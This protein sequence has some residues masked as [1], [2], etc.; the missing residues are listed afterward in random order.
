M[1][2]ITNNNFSDILKQLI[3]LLPSSYNKETSD[4]NYYRLLRALALELENAQVEVKQLS[5]D[6]YLKT[7]SPER[8]FNNF[9]TLVKLKKNADWDD[10]KYR[11]LI[12]GVMQSLLR[13]PTKQSL[14]DG[15]K[16]FT[17]FNVNVYELYKDMDRVD[18]SLYE[19]LSPQFSF[20]LEIEKP[21]EDYA[22]QANLI[23]DANYIV[24]IIKPAHTINLI[25]TT[26]VSDE[27]YR[28]SYRERFGID[29]LEDQ[30]PPDQQ[31]I[32]LPDYYNMDIVDIE[33]LL[34][35]KDNYFGAIHRGPGIFTTLTSKIAGTDVIAPKKILI[36]Y[37]SIDFDF[38]EIEFIQQPT[39]SMDAVSIDR[40]ETYNTLLIPTT[41][42]II[43]DNAE[44]EIFQKPDDG[45]KFEFYPT[46]NFEEHY[47]FVSNG[48]PFF[49]LGSATGGS[50]LNSTAIL[51]SASKDLITELATDEFELVNLQT[52][53]SSLE[54]EG[55]DFFENFAT[56]V[57]D[58]IGSIDSGPTW[59]ETYDSTSIAQLISAF[60]YETT[61]VFNK[62]SITL[63][64]E[65]LQDLSDE[66]LI[67][68][69]ITDL[70]NEMNYELPE[71]VDILSKT[72]TS[73]FDFSITNEDNFDPSSIDTNIDEMKFDGASD[74]YDATNKTSDKVTDAEI[75]NNETVVTP[76]EALELN[77]S[78]ISEAFNKDT[79]I[80]SSYEMENGHSDVHKLQSKVSE[81]K[82]FESDVLMEEDS[83][84]VSLEEVPRFVFNQTPFGSFRL[85]GVIRDQLTMEMYHITMYIQTGFASSQTLE[86]T[87]ET[88]TLSNA[89]QLR[90]DGTINLEGNSNMGGVIRAQVATMTV[91]K[92]DQ[93]TYE[94]NI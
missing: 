25:V 52:I 14:V 77:P 15:L 37:S 46:S 66:I 45:N 60:D 42:E 22:E 68:N 36:D 70:S 79:I 39:S 5:D 71:L 78:E 10:E 32:G 6:M 53:T 85:G 28:K 27:S 59:S 35:K 92:N 29:D 3:N 56:P 91:T 4:T 88:D 19:G 76:I 43:S 94:D 80:D 44:I 50:L 24:S 21:L 20:I 73:D 58:S 74:F 26:L 87:M 7:V 83:T 75:E 63:A 82:S 69:K 8:I 34:T 23:R 11:R 90:M 13:G 1:A 57:D 47:D 61:E 17:N 9:G 51:G 54:I 16:L 33:S 30:L 72:L 81:N 2:D 49:Q 84:I 89:G 38:A 62:Q 93:I 48:E 65:F 64:Q 67:V 41:L 86:Y 18:S 55:L 31:L 12:Q 40:L